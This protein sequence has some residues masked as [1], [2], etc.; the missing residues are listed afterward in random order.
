MIILEERVRPKLASYQWKNIKQCLDESK[1]YYCLYFQ[2][3]TG[4]LNKEEKERLIV[5]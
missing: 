2:Q 4:H 1:Q 3:L 5:L